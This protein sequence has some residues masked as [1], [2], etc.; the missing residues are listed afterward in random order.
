METKDIYEYLDKWYKRNGILDASNTEELTKFMKGLGKEIDKLSATVDKADKLILY[1]GGMEM[2]LCGGW[3][4]A[5][6]NRD[7]AFITYL[8]QRLES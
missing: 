2:C 8:T 7:R 6:R 1:G 3:Q 5:H 4:K